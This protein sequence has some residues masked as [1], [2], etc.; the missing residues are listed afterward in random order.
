MD[1]LYV[2]M[3]NGPMGA[4]GGDRALQSWNFLGGSS[5]L[6]WICPDPGPRSFCASVGKLQ[7]KLQPGIPTTGPKATGQPT[8]NRNGKN[9]AESFPLLKLRVSDD[10]LQYQKEEEHKTESWA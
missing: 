3:L 5:D 4:S 2:F 6:I 7:R 1:D 10:L 9:L 8:T